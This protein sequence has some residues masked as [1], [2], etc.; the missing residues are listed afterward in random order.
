[1]PSSTCYNG[2]IVEPASDDIL[3]PQSKRRPSLRELAKK[4]GVSHTAVA[5]ALRDDPDTSVELRKRV[6][7]IAREE[8]YLASD[9]TQ[10][11]ITGWSGTI[12]VVVP[13]LF[14]PFINALVTGITD[15]LWEDR[16]IPFV[17]CSEL[18]LHREKEM[19][20]ALATKRASG[21]ILMPC[22][23]DRGTHHF[24]HLLKQ[25]TPIVAVNNPIPNTPIPLVASDD[26][27]GARHATRHLVEQGHRHIVH[28]ASVLDNKAS[29]RRREQGYR[30]VMQEAGLKPVVA[31]APA[32]RINLDE[33][34]PVLEQFFD[35][36][37]G[38]RITAVF[39]FNDQM[40]YCVY[41]YAQRRGLVIGKDLALV[42]FGNVRAA[43]VG[44]SDAVDVLNPSL[45]TVDQHPA[46]WGRL[47][48]DMLKA[49]AAGKPV[50]RQTFVEPELIVRDSSRHSDDFKAT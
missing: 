8:G 9:V 25:H 29:D 34:L 36:P 48:V 28:L 17:L 35:S 21:V 5:M 1:M 31:H 4:I 7:Q 10:S 3:I 45:S 23:E 20:T 44:A 46:R 50:P 49:I 47:A 12:G 11:L 30:Q 13:S 40:A 42:G 43:I 6:Q 24:I 16:N 37:A 33:M 15:A 14:S 41:V 26:E 39:A 32:R 19:L 27:L 2:R 18:D 22:R 38:R